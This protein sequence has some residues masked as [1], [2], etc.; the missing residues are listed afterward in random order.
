MPI[1][2]CVTYWIIS[3]SKS[4]SAPFSATPR[5]VNLGTD[6]LP[7]SPIQSWA[8]VERSFYQADDGQSLAT[9]RQVIQV[10]AFLGSK[11]RFVE[12]GLAGFEMSL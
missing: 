8:P 3:R 9:V 6:D 2:R 11:D 4:L 7:P 12:F 10:E 5:D 1:I